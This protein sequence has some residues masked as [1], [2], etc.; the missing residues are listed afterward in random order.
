[1]LKLFEMAK[2][3]KSAIS[4]NSQKL[5]EFTNSKITKISKISPALNVSQTL[6]DL[7]QAHRGP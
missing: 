4:R 1:M 7:H 6:A 2:S 3:T 5:I